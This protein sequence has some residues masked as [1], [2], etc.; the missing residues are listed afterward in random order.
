MM[1]FPFPLCLRQSV[2]SYFASKKSSLGFV[3]VF[4]F[5]SVHTHFRSQMA[6]CLFVSHIPPGVT[7]SD[8]LELFKND[9]FTIG[10]V[11]PLD[12]PGRMKVDCP[13]QC[14][15][16]RIIDKHNGRIWFGARLVVEPWMDFQRPTPRLKSGFHNGGASNPDTADRDN[17]FGRST[18]PFVFSENSCTREFVPREN[19]RKSPSPSFSSLTDLD[20][21]N[22]DIDFD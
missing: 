1:N 9:N 18:T 7:V 15:A 3:T 6:Y 2:S 17:P 10:H 14:M 16:D 4:L 5:K 11:K 22:I 20:D 8:L 19:Y 13:D 12:R 21:N